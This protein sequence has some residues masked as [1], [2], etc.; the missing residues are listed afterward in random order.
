MYP[1]DPLFDQHQLQHRGHT[2]V[3]RIRG[4]KEI[5]CCLTLDEVKIH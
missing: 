4:T 2:H 5:I 1:I 3:T